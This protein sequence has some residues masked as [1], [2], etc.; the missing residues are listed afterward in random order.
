[1][2][3]VNPIRNMDHI[4]ELTKRNLG[5]K[6]FIIMTIFITFLYI[7]AIIVFSFLPLGLPNLTDDK[8]VGFF[9]DGGWVVWIES[10]QAYRLSGFGIM[11]IILT[12]VIIVM[13]TITIIFVASMHSP[14]R[15]FDETIKLVS[16]EKSKEKRRIN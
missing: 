12:S 10:E 14:Y 9:G 5:K 2:N 6:T 16:N 1:M 3:A 4:N 13:W 15:I 7:M 11:M 8:T